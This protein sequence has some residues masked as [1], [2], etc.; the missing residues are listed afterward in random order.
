MQVKIYCLISVSLLRDLKH[1]N[2]VTLHDI[3]H[4]EKSL[5]LVFEYLVSNHVSAGLLAIHYWLSK[6]SYSNSLLISNVC[7]KDLILV[8][9][10]SHDTIFR[11]IFSFD[12]IL[13]C[14]YK[15]DWRML[16]RNN[17]YIYRLC[18]VQC[19]RRVHSSII[20]RIEFKWCLLSMILTL[21]TTLT[22]SILIALTLLL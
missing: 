13:L 20:T 22:N 3:I 21:I 1:A 11:P 2:I 19:H 15:V 18:L 6:P 7:V 9:M 8:K 16:N 12:K 5:T 10:L 17:I 14:E 4:T